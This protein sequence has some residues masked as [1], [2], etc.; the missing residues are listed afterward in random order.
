MQLLREDEAAP[1][2]FAG[3]SVEKARSFCV[4]RVRETNMA[5]LPLSRR[6]LLNRAT[7]IRHVGNQIKNGLWRAFDSCREP[8]VRGGHLASVH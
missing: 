6:T 8:R 2:G 5:I 1:G 3:K 7:I 4:S